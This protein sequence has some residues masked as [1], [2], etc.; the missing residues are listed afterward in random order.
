MDLTQQRLG[1]FTMK[2]CQL[3]VSTCFNQQISGCLSNTWLLPAESADV[4]PTENGCW[5]QTLGRSPT[6]CWLHNA[7]CWFERG[8]KAGKSS[9]KI[10]LAWHPE[11]LFM[12]ELLVNLG[13]GST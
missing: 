6:K 3:G 13:S 10:I 7:F 2:N 8:I 1:K 9:N 12:K 5:Q 11:R 4:F